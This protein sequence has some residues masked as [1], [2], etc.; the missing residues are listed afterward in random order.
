MDVK[1][2]YLA[3]SVIKTCVDISPLWELIP[4]RLR[5]QMKKSFQTGKS[6]ICVDELKEEQ[7][8]SLQKQI[9]KMLYATRNSIVHASKRPIFTSCV[10]PG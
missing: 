8:G 7:L 10:A 6:E 2:D 5:K 3:E 4:E 9:A 1:D